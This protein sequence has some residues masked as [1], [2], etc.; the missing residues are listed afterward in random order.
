[1]SLHLAWVVCVFTPSCH[2]PSPF[3]QEDPMTDCL[4]QSKCS[5]CPGMQPQPFS[6][7]WLLFELHDKVKL[8]DQEAYSARSDKL[9]LVMQFLTVKR[10]RW[11]VLGVGRRGV[12]KFF[13]LSPGPLLPRCCPRESVVIHTE[14]HQRYW[15][16]H[17]TFLL[18][19]FCSC[20]SQCRN[21]RGGPD[22]CVICHRTLLIAQC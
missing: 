2:V 22:S 3:G 9:Y 12:T 13:L 11:C 7:R 15:L 21:E 17:S 5:K 1:M 4:F 8:A 19:L 6:Q 20:S 16:I 18:L 10:C 14:G